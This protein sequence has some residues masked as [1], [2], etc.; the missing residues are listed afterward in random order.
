MLHPGEAAGDE[1]GERLLRPL[2]VVFV[3]VEHQRRDRRMPAVC[4]DLVQPESRLLPQNADDARTERVCGRCSPVAPI[5]SDRLRNKP[6]CRRASP[7]S[8]SF[9]IPK[10]VDDCC[11]IARSEADRYQVMIGEATSGINRV[12]YT[13][14]RDACLRIAR[15]FRFGSMNVQSA[16]V[17]AHWRNYDAN[18]DA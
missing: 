2:P 12:K 7:D 1:I 13:A 15:L 8:L 17:N 4:P 10:T 16:A 18:N 3:H 5:R 9:S 6:S 11:Q 14:K